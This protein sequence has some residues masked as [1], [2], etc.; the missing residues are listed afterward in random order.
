MGR[1][2]RG[3]AAASGLAV[4]LAVTAARAQDE[5]QTETPPPAAA[6][7]PAP[8]E[9]P[10]V[11]NG[12][13]FGAWTVA[14]EA[15][16]VNETTC[17]L[18]Q[19][20][21]RSADNTFLAEL[22]AFWSADLSSGFIAARVPNGVYFPSGFAMRPENSEERHDFVWQSCSRDICE[23]LLAADADTMQSID[24]AG[25]AIIGYRPSIQAEP[26]VFRAGTNGVVEGLNALKQALR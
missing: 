17:V 7:T 19:R 3:M 24:D 15:L 23:A 16:A 9:P 13:R 22:V 2:I 14:C 6:E 20:L 18:S 5:E 26:L 12:A 25:Q 1:A 8:A 21:V 11:V 4:A 10:R